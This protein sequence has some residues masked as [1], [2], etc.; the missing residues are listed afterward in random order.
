MSGGFPATITRPSS[1]SFQ[2]TGG[3]RWRFIWQRPTEKSA[4]FLSG[5]EAFEGRLDEPGQRLEVVAALEDGGEARSERPRPAG[6]LPEA[7][8]G[9]THPRQ[10]VGLVRVEAGGDEDEV[11][12]E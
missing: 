11:G 3:E 6:E 2:G 1:F 7:L 4:A 10:R 5:A 9:Y 8:G 12:P